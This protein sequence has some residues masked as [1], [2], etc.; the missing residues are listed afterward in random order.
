MNRSSGEN[1]PQQACRP[2]PDR[3]ISSPKSRISLGLWSA[4]AFSPSSSFRP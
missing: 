2:Q 1:N 4:R 3:V